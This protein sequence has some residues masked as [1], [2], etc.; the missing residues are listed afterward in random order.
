M[1]DT[2]LEEYVKKLEDMLD[3]ILGEIDYFDS[4]R[5]ASCDDFYDLKASIMDIL[6]E[7]AG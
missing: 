3:R 6:K 5:S 1:E 4:V 7:R 2:K